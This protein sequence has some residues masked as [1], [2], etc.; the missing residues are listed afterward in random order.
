MSMLQRLAVAIVASGIVFDLQDYIE[1]WE[2]PDGDLER[3]VLEHLTFFYTSIVASK[4]EYF[5]FLLTTSVPLISLKHKCLPFIECTETSFLLSLS[6]WRSTLDFF[7][8]ILI[9][10]INLKL[11]FKV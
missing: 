9:Y 6:K 8:S 3:W 11:V 5:S 7:H 10:G 4:V 1:P 2:G